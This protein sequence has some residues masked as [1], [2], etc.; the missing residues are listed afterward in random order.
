MD[1]FQNLFTFPVVTIFFLMLF[2]DNVINNKFFSEKINICG[3]LF[4]EEINEELNNKLENDTVN[5]VQIEQTEKYEDK[6]WDKFINM[7]NKYSFEEEENEEQE[8]KE[9]KEEQEENNVL[10]EEKLNNNLDKLINNFI[11]EKTP[12]GNVIMFYNN[13]RKTF[14]YYSDNTI[15]YRYLE[16]VSRKYVTT[17]SCKPLY[18]VMNDELKKYENKLLEKQKLKEEKERKIKE[19]NEKNQNENITEKKSVF[20]KFKSYNKEAGTGRV[21]TGVPPKNSIPNMKINKDDKNKIILLKEIAN[22]YSYQGKIVNFSI[23]KKISR[24]TV[25]KKYAMTFADFK[26]MKTE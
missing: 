14:D 15:P 3:H 5:S 2:F 21:N 13:K 24:K 10:Q 11:I 16:T 26:K 18:V 4:F 19:E 1:I 9:E 12:L 23:L 25:D 20:A 17:Y 8:E 22:N 7:E 6:Y